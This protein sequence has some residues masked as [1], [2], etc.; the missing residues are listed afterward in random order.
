MEFTY[1]TKD[2]CASE[3]SF[4][5]NDGIVTNIKFNGGCNG[6]LKMVSKLLDGKSAD[7]IVSV[8]SGNT[9]GRRPT[10]SADQLRKASKKAGRK[11][12]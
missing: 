3:I 12:K 8:C 10:S 11:E 1:K 9:C 7:E 2:V 4:D 6:N 5:I